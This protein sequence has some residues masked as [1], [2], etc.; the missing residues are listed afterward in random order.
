MDLTRYSP[1]A[2]G[3]LRM[4]AGLLFLQHGLQKLAGFP[5]SD[6][7]GPA[8]FS[9]FGIGGVIELV[10]GVLIIAGLFT[11]LAAFIASGEMAFAYFLF[12]APQ[13][14]FPV[15]NGGDAAI[16]YCFV[17]LFFVFA[18]AGALSIDGARS[19]DRS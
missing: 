1:Y 10:A 2:H 9:L 7:A 17:F 6:H 5:P 19:R 13:S 12:H 8:L 3:L 16:L 4:V 15:N 11:R 14:P 18:G